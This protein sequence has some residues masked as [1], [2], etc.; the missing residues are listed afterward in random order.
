[1]I[2]PSVSLLALTLAAVM[3][4][5]VSAQQ[6]DASTSA[7]EAEGAEPSTIVVTGGRTRTAVELPGVEMQ[8]ILPGVSP[9]KAIQTLPGVLYITAD[10]WGNNEQNAQLFIHGFAANQLGYTMDGIPLGDQSYGNYNGLSPQRA[11]ISENVGRVVVATG[12]GD[13]ATPSNSNLGGTVETYSANPLATPGIA[14]AQTVGS[15]DTSRTFVRLDTGTFGGTNSAYVSGVRQRARAW[16]FNGIQGGWQANAKFVHDDRIGKLTLYFDYND[17]TQPNEDATVFFKPSAGGTATSTQLYT[18]Y[19]K[20]FFYPDFNGYRTGYLSTLGNSPA[21][22]GGNYRN[23]YSDAQRTDYLAYGRYEARLAPNATLSHTAYY[24]HND[25]AGV[26]AGPLG[27]S[28]TTAQ[29][30][31]DPAYATLPSN[32]RFSANNNGVRPSSCTALTAQQAAAAGAA[33]VAATGGSGLITRTT[34]YRIDR[35]GV[36]SALDV[37][38][39]AHK[40]ELGGWFEHNSTTQWRRWYAVD[41]NNPGNSTPY[42]RPLEVAQPLFTQYQGEAKIE[43]LQLHLQDSWQV[44]DRLLVQAGF[45]TSAQW[46]SGRYPVQPRVGSLSGLT[47]T[48]PEGRINTLR[49]FLPAVGAKFDLNGSEELYANAQKNLRQYQAYLA[50]GGGPWFTGSQTA[51]N[52]F[53]QNGRPES[54]WTYEAGLRSNRNLG[55]GLSLSAQVNYY[56]VD[57][58]DRLLAISTNPGGI[59]GGAITGGTSI[60]VN[61]GNV[62]TDGIDAAFT[63]RAGQLFSLYN[64]TSYNLSKYQS[65]YTSTASGIGAATDTCIGGFLVTNGVV[66]TCGKQLPGIPKWMNKTVANL[67]LGPIDTQVIGDYVG[68]RYATFSNDARVSSYFLTSLRVA[69]RVP[70]AILPLR[71][72]ELALNVTNLTDARGKSTLSVGSATN[73]FSAYPIPPRQWFLTFSAAY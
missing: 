73:S 25:G 8:K 58:R 20:P 5:T 6:A 50:G 37:D 66:P 10:P 49:W 14:A 32:C 26:V 39:G 28:I 34:E 63:L 13:L 36:I 24:H 3:P 15:Y 38:L 12:A 21:A 19:T 43:Q 35:W 67:T 71:K 68:A 55:G 1:M 16:D 11:V 40:I 54:S 18:P 33:L 44:F 56:H 23:Y 46:A 51:F 22:Q 64:A 41:A 42:I 57:F 30:Y 2:H 70:D 72:A 59:A 60:L 62:K 17:M 61:V 29:A 69:A 27:Q 9:L 52:A 4:A 48:L 65:D 45:K 7:R 31:L 53:A 47:S